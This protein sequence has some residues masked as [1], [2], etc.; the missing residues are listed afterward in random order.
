MKLS[1]IIPVYNASS[2]LRP[3]LDSVLGQSLREIE[4]ICV[5][6]GSTD[7]GPAVL[8]EYA[9]RDSRVRVIRQRNAGAGA[10]RNAGLERANG[11]YVLFLDA[12]DML[13]E[14]SLEELWRQAHRLRLDVLRCRA[15]DY[16]NVT[17]A[18]TRSLHNALRRVPPFMFGI[19]I[20][21][22]TAYWLFPKVN[23]SPWGGLFRRGFLLENGIR[24]NSLIC[25]ND[26]SFFWE[27]ILKAD[28]IAFSRT[29]LLLYRMNLPG[30]LVGNRL[31]HFECHFRSYELV[32]GICHDL[33]VKCRRSILDA[34]MLD[35]ANWYESAANTPLAPQIRQQV[36]GF[37]ETM[38]LDPWNG[39]VNDT[40]WYKRMKNV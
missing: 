18:V 16:D 2:Y 10:S 30:S 22:P 6:D 23:V 35:M 25:V 4:V 38:E 20:K 36:D 28:R 5:D 31:R 27:S 1:I 12:D 9:A 14:D 29:P 7:E 40:K 24:F 26:R 11:E 37:L 39:H 3:C 19:P 17:G 15:Y 13:L 21:Y 34:E 8:G 33:P 32:S